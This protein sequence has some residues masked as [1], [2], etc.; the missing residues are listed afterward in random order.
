VIADLSEH[1]LEWWFVEGHFSGEQVRETHF[2]ISL[3]RNSSKGGHP[4][5]HMVLLSTFDRESGPHQVR[6]EISSSMVEHFI[7]EMEK[8][9]EA[10]EENAH[11]SQ[12]LIDEIKNYGVPSP[13]VVAGCPQT[14]ARD[15]LHIEWNDVALCPDKRTIALG[16]RLPGYESQCDLTL[17]PRSAWLLER[18]CGENRFG[19]MAY[20]SCPRLHLTGRLGGRF[21]EGAAW[22]DHQWG[23]PG[24]LRN[25]DRNGDPL[26]WVW[27][28][29]NLD[30]GADLIIGQ[31]SNRRTG[32]TVARFAVYFEPGRDPVVLSDLHLSEGRCWTSPRSMA[33]YVLEW[34]IQIPELALFLSFRPLLDDQEIPVFGA[35]NA[36]WEGAGLVS[37]TLA[38]QPVSGRARLELQGYANILDV[39]AILTRWVERIDVTLREFLPEQLDHSHLARWAGTPRLAI[40]AQAHTEGLSKPV[41][42]LLNRGGKHWRPIFGFLLLDVLGVDAAPYETLFS[43]MPEF[44]HNGSVIVDDIEDRSETRRGEETLHLRYGLA[45]A[46]NAENMLYFLPILALAEQPELS[47]SQRDEIYRLLVRTFVQA[48]LGQGQDLCWSRTD[49]SRPASFWL[50]ERLGQQILEAHAF[51][52]AALVRAVAEIACIIAGSPLRTRTICAEFAEALGLAF[53]IVDDINNFTKRPEWGKVRGEDLAGGKASYVIYNAINL[54]PAPQRDELIDIVNEADLRGSAAGFRRGIELIEQ[55]GAFDVCR[56]EAEAMVEEHWPRFS[57]VV[58]QSQGKIMMRLL[59]THLLKLPLEM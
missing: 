51:K 3:F 17:T 29:I 8:G 35:M 41:W 57:E 28:G 26:C 48:H 52:T 31:R 25:D 18:E 12:A 21:V 49:Q 9:T 20:D 15:R 39:S 14:F 36:I 23:D 50:D 45:T 1:T 11:L 55:S 58:G 5:G 6:S 32:S 44:I 22:F 53:Q 43:V 4:D 13:I 42:D 34:Q 37:G 54:L 40:D 7:S 46:L 19:A 2:M 38:G 56:E 27:F 30:N 59:V 10:E 16:F 47:A 33:S 24:W